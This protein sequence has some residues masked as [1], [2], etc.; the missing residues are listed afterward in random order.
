MAHQAT[1]QYHDV[2]SPQQEYPQDLQ[3]DYQHAYQQAYHSTYPQGYQQDPQVNYDKAGLEVVPSNSPEIRQDTPKYMVDAPQ[4]PT[5]PNQTQN[6]QGAGRFGRKRMALF[7]SGALLLVIVAL[8]V[9]AGVLGSRLASS[10]NSTASADST[11]SGTGGGG[12]SSSSSTNPAPNAAS[13]SAGTATSP[14]VASTTSFSS[15]VTYSATSYPVEQSPV[16]ATLSVGGAEALIDCPYSNNTVWVDSTTG[17]KFLRQC[18]VNP[19]GHDT[20]TVTAS[21]LAECMA[22]CASV[23]A[24][25]GGSNACGAVVWSWGWS[26]AV[27]TDPLWNACYLKSNDWN[28][29]DS[30]IGYA[31]WQVELAIVIS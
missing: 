3:H 2:P 26:G 18:G 17:T 24:A 31:A 16:L 11:A 9:V 22:H 20:I 19:T 23:R 15:Y 28:K 21:S 27:A 7:L 29:G 4:D 14:V 1:D 10:N 5:H 25:A 8:A 13:T 30:Y 12:G 6:G